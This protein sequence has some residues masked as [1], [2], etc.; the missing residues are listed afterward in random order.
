MEK[1]RNVAQRGVNPATLALVIEI[2]AAPLVLPYG[3]MKAP[4]TIIPRS[5]K[6]VRL[7][8]R[9]S[10][11]PSHLVQLAQMLA[12]RHRRPYASIAAVAASAIRSFRDALYHP[13][14]PRSPS[15]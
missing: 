9:S 14:V 7:S 13:R 8:P 10:V 1:P 6:Y 2:I 11:P 4:R 15:G 5:Q 3:D 12:R